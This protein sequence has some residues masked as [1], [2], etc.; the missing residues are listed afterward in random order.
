MYQGV[1]TK[2]NPIKELKIYEEQIETQKFFIELEQRKIIKIG[3]QTIP[4]FI[5]SSLIINCEEIIKN[6]ELKVAY[7]E[8]C[9][10]ELEQKIN[11]NV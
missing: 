11:S 3:T 10:M 1:K 4:S 6:H 8:L 7:F 9:K 2:M 5:K